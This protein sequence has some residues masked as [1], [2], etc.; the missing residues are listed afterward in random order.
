LTFIYRHLHEHD[1]QQFTMR[2]GVLTGNDTRWHSTSSGSPLPE[3]TNGWTTN[4]WKQSNMFNQNT[5][6]MR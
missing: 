1:Q 3:R 5:A 4:C 2:S 6:R